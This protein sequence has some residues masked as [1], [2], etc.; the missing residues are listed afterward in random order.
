ME[1]R[2]DGDPGAKMLGIGG[3]GKHGFGRRLEQEAVD[4]GLV[5]PGNRSDRGWQREHHVIIGQRQ[6][7]GLAFCKPLACSRPL[8]LRAMPVTAGVV[9]D[10]GVGA[11]F[12][13]RNMAA[14][15][16]RAAGFDGCHRFES[17]EAQMAGVGLAPSSPMAAEDIRNLKRGTR[18]SRKRL[19][20]RIA[21]LL[22]KGKPVERA[23]HLADRACRHAR[24]KRRRVEL[25]VS[26]QNLDHPDVDILLQKMRRKA[27]PK[28]VH[29]DALVDLRHMGCRMAGAV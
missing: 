20:R 1:H 28:R 25:G 2:R 4:G 17:P 13:S 21:P 26:Q 24:V 8:T 16:C 12:A 10:D 29:G 15:L 6:K 27:V 18:H 23:H 5:L 7:L 22:V 9:A 14:K 11:V 3:N 19:A